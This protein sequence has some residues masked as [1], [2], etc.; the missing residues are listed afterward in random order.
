MS[1]WPTDSEYLNPLFFYLG[2]ADMKQPKNL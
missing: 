1:D 2:Y